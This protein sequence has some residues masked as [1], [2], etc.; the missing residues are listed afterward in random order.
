M[1]SSSPRTRNRGFSL[2][3]SLLAKGVRDS[4][5]AG[6]SAHELQDVSQ[7]RGPLGAGTRSSETVLTVG[8]ASE[9]DDANSPAKKGVAGP[10]LPH[11]E[12]WARKTSGRARIT[13]GLRQLKERV[14]KI[15]LR[16]NDVPASK[17]G[18]HVDLDVWRQ[19]PRVDERYGRAYIDNSIRSSRYTTWNF[20]PRQ[21]FAQFSK[22]ANFYFLC[23]S[24]LQLIPG[25]STTG[26][27]TTIV[28]LLFFVSL[29]MA[30]EGYEDL[31]RHRLDK[32]DNNSDAS[33]MRCTGKDGAT[34]GAKTDRAGWTTVKWQDIRV[35]DVVR[36]R[37]DEA[38]P[39]DLVLLRAS[40]PNGIAYI[41]TMALDG[42]TNLKSKQAAPPLAKSCATLD[43]LQ[44]SHAHLV[45]EDPNA[46]LYN[47]EGRV[48]TAGETHPLTTAEVIY[49][50]S[51]LRNTT[52]AVGIAIYTG[53]ECKI[54]MNATKNPRIKAPSLQAVVNKVVIAIVCFVV[55][56]AVF[57]T[58]AYQFWKEDVEKT[59][60]YL[61]R[62]GVA[63]FP[64][65]AS[66]V[67][68]FNTL[69][70]LSL[71]VILEIV[72]LAQIYFMNDIDMY[73]EA[74]DTPMEARTSTINEELGQ[75]R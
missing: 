75:V 7:P 70:P 64:V 27:F 68:M 40:G 65:L 18:R 66:F 46:D 34:N 30:K 20:L 47:F 74:S 11:Y 51:V 72:K 54:R 58:V 33:A 59:S 63:T 1:P 67:I 26:T 73:D 53:E 24:I 16:I 60:W 61:A 62:A 8:P 9:S 36:L 57:N 14:R 12:T 29:S 21:L 48:T 19:A 41:E 10:A 17:D 45:V 50:G 28:P 43:G 35:G 56:L 31:R 42:E 15:I 32:A 49:R 55:A 2:R 23:I 3:R 25:L 5:D 39:A 22:L 69:I 38:A 4:A 71:Y 13:T 52:E 37:R 44:G 6:G